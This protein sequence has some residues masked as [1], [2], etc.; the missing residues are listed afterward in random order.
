MNEI[1]NVVGIDLILLFGSVFL[2]A[3]IFNIVFKF[4]R[5]L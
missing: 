5:Q 3:I 2:F 1:Y 4:F